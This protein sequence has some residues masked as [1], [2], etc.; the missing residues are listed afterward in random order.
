[1]KTVL[2]LGGYGN[3]G[4]YIS[5]ALSKANIFTIIAGRNKVAA[6]TF[7][8]EILQTYPAAKLTVAIFDMEQQLSE[9]LTKLKPDVVINTCGPFQNKNYNTALTC[10]QHKTHYI[11]LADGREFVKNIASLDTQAKAVGVMVISGASTVPGLSSAVI[12]HFKEQFKYIDSLIY[13]IAP[14]QKVAR[15]LATTQAIL[16]YLGKPIKPAQGRTDIRYGWQ[17]L[18]RQRYPI[19]GKRWM[20][21]C[22]IPDLDLLPERYHIKH[23]TFSAGMESSLLHFGMW[24]LSWLVRM[25]IPLNLYKY[26]SV[27]LK[28]SH[29]FDRLGTANSGM[30]ILLKGLD[31]SGKKKTIEWYLIAKQG[32]GPQVPTIPAIVLTKK[33]LAGELNLTGAMPC[34]GLVTLEEYLA[35]LREF[36]IK[37]YEK[38]YV[39]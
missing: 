27:L 14:G 29:W 3:F 13:G 8:K 25:G 18:Y 34:V 16:S 5:H 26:A 38:D 35:E 11:D 21:N 6:E 23:I 28:L 32:D 7:V 31:H 12:E 19:I 24:G 1:M 20:A 10:I 30:H 33:L 36:N 9:Q 37:I 4:K 15:G 17:D 39:A 22:E 2:V